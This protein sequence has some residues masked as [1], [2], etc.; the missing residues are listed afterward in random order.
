MRRVRFRLQGGLGNQLFIYYAAAA[1][2]IVHGNEIEFETSALKTAQTKREFALGDFALPM[3]YSTLRVRMPRTRKVLSRIAPH[4]YL[5]R[6]SLEFAETGFNVALLYSPSKN[7]S[8]YFQSWRYVEMVLSNLPGTSLRVLAPSDWALNL[9]DEARV[10]KPIACHI[11]RG[12][13]INLSEDFG[14]LDYQFYLNAV[15]VLRNL[16]ATGPV[17]IF[18]DS[19]DQIDDSF[20]QKISGLVI[21][22]PQDC[23]P[24]D[25]FH[26]MQ[27]CD[28][29]VIS[30]S[31]FSWWAAFTAKSNHVVAPRPWFRN[32]SEP[33][34]LLPAKWHKLQSEWLNK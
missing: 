1:Y 20:I 7:I 31:T 26:V 17:W 19:P 30:N 16:G 9:E 8:G 33:I 5:R 18:S 28:S 27:S 13:Y 25:V 23:K 4:R 2:S 24:S 15:N 12:D 32:L 6:K 3:Q 11:R 21:R 14:V 22:E 10:Q 34:D 29:F